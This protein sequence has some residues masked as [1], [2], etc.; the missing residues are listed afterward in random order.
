MFG[1]FRLVLAILV[2]LSHFGFQKYNINPGQ[3]AVISFY[4]LSGLLMQRQFSKF[5]H[6]SNPCITFYVDRFLRVAPLY[7]LVCIVVIIT[8]GGHDL[9]A[10]FLLFPLSY[11]S[12]TGVQTLIMPAWSLSSEIHFYLLLPILALSSTRILR[13][14]MWGSWVIFAIAPFLEHSTFW[15]YYGAPGTLFVFVAG[16]LF[17]REE[18]MRRIFLATLVLGCI[19]L[20]G[21]FLKAP[22]PSGININVCFGFII[23]LFVIPKLNGLAPNSWDQRIGNL[24]FPL[25]LCHSW[26]LGVSGFTNMFALLFLSLVASIFLTV[27]VESPFDAIRY[28]VRKRIQSLKVAV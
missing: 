23:A 22:I 17:A 2:A 4:M 15:S 7:W 6:S 10:N 18:S 3:W 16:M 13:Y 12:L 21:K 27:V 26:V 19:F 9:L 28:W 24:T 25:F 11:Q 20:L 1:T 5:Q 14:L 8:L